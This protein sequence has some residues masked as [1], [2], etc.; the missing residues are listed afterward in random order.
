M[1]KHTLPP[2]LLSPTSLQEETETDLY[3]SNAEAAHGANCSSILQLLGCLGIQLDLLL[4]LRGRY[5]EEVLGELTN[6]HLPER[7]KKRVES[8]HVAEQSHRTTY[9]P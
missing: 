9:L 4:L 6:I 7:K 2:L 1:P 8:K 5:T 3:Y